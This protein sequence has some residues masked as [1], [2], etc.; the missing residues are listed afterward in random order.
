MVQTNCIDKFAIVVCGPTGSG[1]T[2]LAIKLANLF[3][4]EII[5]ADSIAIYKGL[6][7]GAAKP[8]NYEKSLAV[9]HMIDVVMPTEEFSVAEYKE[10]AR[11]ILFDI[12]NRNKTPIICGGTGYYIDALLYDFSYGNCP[13]DEEF[14]LECD[15]IIENE[16]IEVLYKKLQE[17]DPETAQILHLND[18]MRIVRA[19]EIYHTTGQ[20]KSQI[21]DEKRA[22]IPFFAFSYQDDREKLYSKINARVDKMFDDGLMDEVKGLIDS[23]VSPTAQSMQGIGYKEVV[24]GLNNNFTIEQ[25]KE[26][27][28]LNTRHYAKRQITW[29][30]RLENLQY[31]E[32]TNEETEIVKIK[33]YI[34]GCTTNWTTYL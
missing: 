21:V 18:K 29:F 10:M 9:H 13:K 15:K 19:L 3:D 4:G 24:D 28:K 6:D 31:I 22:I 14:R 12:L 30:K 8:D 5:S 7:I 33:E 11:K 1:K 16:G 25:I 34:D 20:K 26:T 2:K 23:G 27:I 32:R 17:V